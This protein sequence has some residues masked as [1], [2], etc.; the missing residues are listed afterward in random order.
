MDKILQ[1]VI[2]VDVGG[3]NTDAA[4]L[5]IN[6]KQ[7]RVLSSA[8]SITT[9][10]VTS[11]I[12]HA[13]LLAIS[14]RNKQ[15]ELAIQR[16]N[17]GTTH[18]VNA[19]VQRK[20]L[21]KVTVLR[22]CGTA[23][24][25]VPP[26]SDFPPDLASCLNGG[27]HFVSG[28]YQVDG[29]EISPIDRLE[30]L[31]IV[32]ESYKEGISN[33]VICGIFSPLR[34]EQ[35]ELVNTIILSKFPNASITLSNEIGHAGLIE[36]ENAAILNESLKP[37][38]K[39]TI[40]GFTDA[41][42]SLR[43]TC[44]L[45]LTQNDGTVVGEEYAL[46]HPVCTFAS[47]PTNS[48]RGAAFLSGIKDG[49]VVDIGGTTTDVG[50]L[51]KGFPREASTEIKIG[52]VR[53][54][55]RMPD[56]HSIGLGGGSYVGQQKEDDKFVVTV[57]P[58]SAAYNIMN[59]AFVFQSDISSC[60][61]ECLT[62][63]DLAVAA[64]HST[65]G[66]STNVSHLP[67]DLV[68]KG[69][70]KI[71]S[72]VEIAIDSVKLSA[73]P[74]PVILVGGGGIILDITKGLEGASD[75]LFPSHFEVAN[76]VGAALSQMSGSVEY[77][78]HLAEEIS[79]EDINAK[80]TTEMEI[81][82]RE[83]YDDVK[84]RIRKAIMEEAIRKAKEDGIKFASDVAAK[85]GVDKETIIILEKSDNP[86]TYLPG[87]AT[88]INC[89]VVGDM[90]STNEA[91]TVIIDK[92]FILPSEQTLENSSKFEKEQTE[93]IINAGKQDGII[94]QSAPFIN[95][96]NEWI[97]SVYDIECIGIGAGILGCGGG[98]S[99]NLGKVLAKRAIING[100]EIK[101]V[102][103]DTFF[104]NRSENNDL[105]ALS[106]FI[107]APYVISEKLVSGEILTALRCMKDLYA[108][109]QYQDGDLHIKDGVD[110][111]TG[112]GCTFI[113]DYA[114]IS[115]RD[116]GSITN[117]EGKKNIVGLMGA[118]IGGLNA[119]EPLLV[120]AELGLPVL[121]CDGMGRAFPELQMLCPF[122]YG[123]K[124]YPAT[125]ADDKG[126]RAVALHMDTAKDLETF[127]RRE[128]IEMGC[129]AG[130]IFSTLTK[131]EVLNKTILLSYSRAWNLGNVI[132]TSRKEKADPIEAIINH[133][134]GKKLISGKITDVRRETTGG[135]SKGFVDVTGLESF[136]GQFL[137]IEFQNE[138]LIARKS[139]EEKNNTPNVVACTPDL[140]TIVDNDTAEPITTEMVRYG[141]RCSVLVLPVPDIM[142]TPKALEV[143]GP[144]AFG[145][146]VNF[147]PVANYKQPKPVTSYD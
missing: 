118:E 35:E 142:K 112:I 129:M 46:E 7:P 57:G 59:E 51:R 128:T 1:C 72:M 137:F 146:H 54:N 62:A 95:E 119:I 103:P 52:G 85:R 20:E 50:I 14:Q 130:I 33:F 139:T 3:T 108:V 19:V 10:D 60:R 68:K 77:V 8:K 107:G 141:L 15:Q 97:L 120:G 69:I 16:V 114:T 43:L 12:S 11:G 75:L 27:T 145:Y 73:E 78:V 100:K 113:K 5:Q 31:K 94:V 104:R 143:V 22:L 67:L 30:I 37:L 88:R 134:D 25:Q 109:G 44:P 98:G 56:V 24:R 84:K 121:D 36:R 92:D 71:K 147:T 83:N 34:K 138:N 18:F 89:K 9:Q 122:I 42:L 93:H 61:M 23:S 40:K 26:F 63:T 38:C 102:N 86:M 45:Y 87:D 82:P 41:L 133:E 99:P 29:R 58:R 79:E 140:I 4:I 80:T 6:C 96:N 48:M 144:Q 28:G 101:I 131:S 126:R 17:I 76:A 116:S 125:L 81:N 32:S 123:A 111:E 91:S 135:F 117:L 13:I 49:I 74:L 55:F 21:T 110:I 39:K 136:S 66:N 47:G 132:M 90:K 105:I 124:P 65:L 2:G 106:A 70:Q 53:T 115:E 64:G 127:F